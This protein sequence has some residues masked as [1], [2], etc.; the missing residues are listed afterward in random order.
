M[1]QASLLGIDGRSSPLPQA[2]DAQQLR[3]LSSLAT[4]WVA[5]PI[6][7]VELARRGAL[8]LAYDGQTSTSAGR[9]EIIVLTSGERARP[10]LGDDAWYAPAVLDVAPTDAVIAG[11]L[12]TGAD[13]TVTPSWRRMTAG[14]LVL[15]TFPTANA[16][17]KIRLAIP[18]DV[19][20]ARWMYV[21]AR[22]VGDTT[23]VG[24]LGLR[25]SVSL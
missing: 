5:T 2:G 22:E 25:W 3:A 6:V 17:D 24:A 19:T 21:A 11:T 20:H 13:Y 9:P 18:L 15:R 23:N 8:W 1:S 4:E 10:A 7:S 12:P 16:T 14:G